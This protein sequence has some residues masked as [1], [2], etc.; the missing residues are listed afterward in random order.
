MMGNGPQL[1]TILAYVVIILRLFYAMSNG[2]ITP[3]LSR[4]KD[5][6]TVNFIYY[7][8]KC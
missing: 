3:E 7:G 1:M 8:L 6:P 5:Y 4:M 2:I